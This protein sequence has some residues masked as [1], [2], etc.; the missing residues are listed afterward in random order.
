MIQK[1]GMARWLPCQIEF[2]L[3]RNLKMKKE[4][5][6]VSHLNQETDTVSYLLYKQ[7]MT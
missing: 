3:I 1:I 4:Y 6:S 7:A 5:I 2:Q